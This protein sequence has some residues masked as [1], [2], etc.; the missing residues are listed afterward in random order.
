MN[1]RFASLSAALLG[2]LAAAGFLVMPQTVL[3]ALVAD[4]GLAKLVAAAAPPLGTLARGLMAVAA[5]G[6]AALLGFGLARAI[7]G[8]PVVNQEPAGDLFV[9]EPAEV[10]P[11]FETPVLRRADA[12]PDAPPRPPLRAKHELGTPFLEVRAEEDLANALSAADNIEAGALVDAQ[13]VALDMEQREAL[14]REEAEVLTED[15]GDQPIIL[16]PPDEV[17]DSQA[18]PITAPEIVVPE[19]QSLPEDFDQPLAAFDPSAIRGEPR[20]GAPLPLKAAQS[21]VLEAGERFEIFEISAPLPI[22]PSVSG[23]NG[24]DVAASKREQRSEDAIARPETD[25]T[26][27]ALLERLER[28]VSRKGLALNL[29]PVPFPGDAGTGA[30]RGLEDALVSLRNLARRA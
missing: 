27:H 20:P 4:L 30:E 8:A 13:P 12:H 22:T 2:V 5:G 18:R 25:A 28:G 3:E 15:D 6:L 16:L 19:E 21:D 10:A 24:G 14:L 23:S 11:D 17:V 26:I 29:K 1:L 7:L 9:S